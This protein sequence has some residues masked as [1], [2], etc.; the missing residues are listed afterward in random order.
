MQKDENQGRY[1]LMAKMFTEDT[2]EVKYWL[3]DRDQGIIAHNTGKEES[4]L[5]LYLV[6]GTTDQVEKLEVSE[7]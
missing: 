3:K 4:T 5:N 7:F 2:V 1:Y 6:P